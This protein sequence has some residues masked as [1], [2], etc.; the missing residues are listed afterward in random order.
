[1]KKQRVALGIGSNLGE[2]LENIN[3]AIEMLKSHGLEEIKLSQLVSSE[4]VDCPTGSGD[5]LNGALIGMWSLSCRA[6]M[7]T[8][9][10]IEQKLGRLEIRAVNSPRPIDLDILLFESEII[11][12]EDLIVP[13]PRMLERDFVMN[14]LCEVAA[15]WIIPSK[16][17]NVRAVCKEFL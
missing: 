5:F 8:C 13:H 6:L 14:P 9:Q 7:E 16:G 10:L 11:K 2:R 3:K 12:D 1:M 15:E 17:V 4:P